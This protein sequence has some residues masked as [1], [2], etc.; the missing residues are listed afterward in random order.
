[1]VAFSFVSYSDVYLFF[2]HQLA[3]QY[4]FRWKFR[5][6]NWLPALAGFGH[7]FRKATVVI[8]AFVC[9]V[10]I[11]LTPTLFRYTLNLAPLA[12]FFILDLLLNQFIGR[13]FDLLL[14]S[15]T[16]FPY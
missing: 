1:M 4:F 11:N 12:F 16:W 2:T 10:I 9:L 13:I 6:R 14:L 8:V 3:F 15:F 5:C 7:L